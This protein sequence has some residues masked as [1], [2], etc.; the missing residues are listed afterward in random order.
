MPLEVDPHLASKHSG[1][2]ST[3]HWHRVENGNLQCDLYSR[4]V[5]FKEGQRGLCFVSARVDNEIVM[6]S[7]GRSSRFS[8]D[9]IEQKPLIIFSGVIGFVLRHCWL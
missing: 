5:K 6:T 4:A 2:V 9:P 3:R 1:V 7:Y 8:V